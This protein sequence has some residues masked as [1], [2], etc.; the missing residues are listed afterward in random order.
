MIYAA[1][2]KK[3]DGCLTVGGY[4]G[5]L[6]NEAFAFKNTAAF[7]AKQSELWQGDRFE[8]NNLIRMHRKQVEKFFGREFAISPRSGRIFNC[9]EEMFAHDDMM[10]QWE[11]DDAQECAAVCAAA[12]NFVEA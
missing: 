8:G 4:N 1:E 5:A 11:K 3:T 2:V 10:R 7:D 9:S 6:L 12:E